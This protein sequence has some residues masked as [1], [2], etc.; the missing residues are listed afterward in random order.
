MAASINDIL[1]QLAAARTMITD[2][3]MNPDTQAAFA[4]TLAGQ[5][6]QMTDLDLA[7]ASRISNALTDIGFL[8]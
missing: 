7:G 4:L 5:V 8:R 6:S 1:S 3:Q 2:Q